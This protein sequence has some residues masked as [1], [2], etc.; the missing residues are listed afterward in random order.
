MFNARN[1]AARWL[2]VLAAVVLFLATAGTAFG[3]RLDGTLRGEVTDPS[4]AVVPDAKVTVTNVGTRVSQT[5][6]TTSAGT[7][8][9]PNLL[10]GTYTV[11]VEKSG[12]SK[13]TR[14][15]VQISSNQVTEVNPRLTVGAGATTVEV[16]AGSE[17]LRV[18]DSQLVN[19]FDSTQVLSLPLPPAPA[20]SN[21]VLNLAILAPNTTTQGGGVLGQG[22]SI[23]GARPRMNNFTVDGTDD[24]RVDITGPQ[25]NIIGD[26]VADF[27]LITNM[28]SAEYGHSAG[29]QFNITTKSGT[30]NFHGTAF[31]LNNNRN[32]NAFDNVEKVAQSC[33]TNPNCDKTRFD[34]NTV[35]GTIGGPIKK[36]KLFFFAGYQRVFA[37]FSGT[38]VV[39]DAPTAAGL[40][41]LKSVA[42]DAPVTDILN[43]FPTAPSA[44]KPSQTVT[45]TRTG[46]TVTVP[47]G[48]TALLAPSFYD[49][50]DVH[51]NGDINIWS[52]HQIRLRYLY[53]RQRSPNVS[54]SPLAQFTGNQFFD[55]NRATATDAWTINSRWVSDI[56]LGYTRQFNGFAVPGQF[57]NFPNVFVNVLSNFFIGPEQ[58]SP[59]GG[60]QNVYQVLE[61]MTYVKGRHTLK[62]GAEYRRWIALS[63][64]L[65][66]ARGEWQYNTLSNLINDTVPIDFAKRGAGTEFFVGNQTGASGYFQDDWKVTSNVTLNLGLRYEWIGIP[67]DSKLQDLN[68]LSNLPGT[69]FI[70]RKPKSDTNNWAPRLGFAWDPRGNAKWAV[71]GGFG[72]SYDLIAQNFPLLSLPPQLQ[73][74]QDPDISCALPNRPSWCAS[75]L[76]PAD[77]TGRGFLAGGG[78]LQVNV[79]CDNTAD[80]RAA[81]QGKIPD[82]IMPKVYTWTVSVQHELF[83]N[84]SLELRYLG[85]RA[86]QLY[87][88]TQLNAA[89]AFDRGAKP[90]PVF[91]SQSAVPASFA[92]TAPTLAAFNAIAAIRPFQSAGFAGAVTT[93]TSNADSIYHSG[94]VDFTHRMSRGLF[95]RANYT[96]AHTIDTGTNELFSSLVNPRRPEDANHVDRER[97]RSVLDIHHK[98]A[99]SWVYELPNIHSDSLFVKT[100]LHGWGWNGTYLVQTGQ[101][102]NVRS[103]T[104]SNGNKDSAGDRAIFNPGGDP[105]KSSDVTTVC[106]D[107]TARSFG[108]ST[109]SQIV[110]YVARDSTAGFIRARAGALTNTGRNTITSPGRNNFDMS[111]F[112]NT[113]FSERFTLQFRAE[114]TNIFNHRQYSFSNP[115][116]FPIRGIDD[117]AINAQAFVNAN[118]NSD[119]RNP[120]Q[121]NGGSRKMQLG[122]KLLF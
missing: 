71:R 64:F 74:E 35:G 1:T 90:L 107:G 78:L 21:A 3:Q 57:A 109:A 60:G 54:E 75:F 53:N 118:G 110:G 100:F 45:N 2:G 40:A 117:S 106:W 23:G 16:V 120:Q 5:T 33:D 70:F 61:Q 121:L 39:I 119:F 17:V 79:P 50:H 26:A 43:Q 37:G 32:Y 28:F 46:T 58:N 18:T 47:I 80:C 29:G 81:T 20:G 59:Q 83:R 114:T 91:F 96:W 63:S 111:L 36:E 97:G 51:A 92:A 27:T 122:L 94:S 8:T 56:R 85:T 13:Y 105:F 52:K 38:S 87:V 42:E 73:S 102:V 101:P 25:S 67:R 86:S 15:N 112:K 9:F 31:I 55:V 68:G 82:Q 88:Q 44:T 104:D 65:P 69:P 89:S 24:N 84:S 30:N 41:A 115:G 48:Q 98:A 34:F 99:I 108:C 72:V 10:V 49:E 103:A 95:L 11:T 93:F 116:V 19:T 22:G 4:G 62:W 7:Y 76:N 6:N 77:G 12:F 14:T 66:R 113:K